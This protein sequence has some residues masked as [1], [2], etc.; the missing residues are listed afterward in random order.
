MPEG[1]IYKT[2]E[3]LTKNPKS[4]KYIGEWEDCISATTIK[5]GRIHISDKHPEWMD[6]V[7]KFSRSNEEFPK[8]WDY[9]LYKECIMGTFFYPDK[10][11]VH[12]AYDDK[13]K[14]V[15]RDYELND[16]EIYVNYDYFN[17]IDY[18]CDCHN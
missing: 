2:E 10:I 18:K 14:V 4:R 1:K 3:D 11:L 15:G 9:K 8:D 7:L 13:V 16:D 12:K 17:W 6:Y 5:E